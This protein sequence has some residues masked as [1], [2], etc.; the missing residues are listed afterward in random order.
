MIPN[1]TLRSRA[2]ALAERLPP[3]ALAEHSLPQPAALAEH[4]LSPALAE[5]S[6]LLL[7]V[8]C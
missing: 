6:L 4:S 3:L 2:E 8:Q 1:P 5:R 7:Q